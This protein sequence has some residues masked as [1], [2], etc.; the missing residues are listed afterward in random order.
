MIRNSNKWR[1]SNWRVGA[2]VSSKSTSSICMN[3][4]AT[5]WALNQ[6][7]RPDEVYLTLNTHFEII[8]LL[9]DGN[10]QSL[11]VLI[12]SNKFSSSSITN[13]HWQWW[14]EWWI[15]CAYVVDSWIS[16]VTFAISEI[17]SSELAVAALNCMKALIVTW[18]TLAHFKWSS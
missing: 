4:Q 12:A 2:N 1:D 17:R 10:S 7:T 18:A 15:T 5:K 16:S 8:S 3:S 11:N 14:T 9:D 6:F 13:S